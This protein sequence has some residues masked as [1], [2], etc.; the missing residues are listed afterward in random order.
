[1]KINASI[2]DIME[3]G[4]HIYV[5]TNQFKI[6]RLSLSSVKEIMSSD[7]LGLV[8]IKLTTEIDMPS[9][10]ISNDSCMYWHYEEYCKEMYYYP[11]RENVMVYL[12]YDSALSFARAAISEE[13]TNKEQVLVILRQDQCDLSNDVKW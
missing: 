11:N 3:I 6:L 8:A 7:G 13:I 10:D 12:T 4:Q 2:G 1:M 5:V 9:F